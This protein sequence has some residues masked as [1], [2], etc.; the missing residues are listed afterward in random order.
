MDW[1][2]VSVAI[3]IPLIVSVIVWTLTYIIPYIFP[4][5][6]SKVLLTLFKKFQNPKDPN[7]IRVYVYQ[8]L[9]YADWK[10]LTAKGVLE[11]I[12]E[13][14][15]INFESEEKEFWNY[16]KNQVES[17]P[18]EDAIKEI[19]NR[20]NELGQPV[21]IDGEVVYQG[22]EAVGLSRTLDWYQDIYE[23]NKNANIWYFKELSRNDLH[24]ILNIDPTPNLEQGHPPA[25]FMGKEMPYRGY[26]SEELAK[27]IATKDMKL[28][29]VDGS[30]NHN[31]SDDN[32]IPSPE[33][34]L[35]EIEFEK[36]VDTTKNEK[37]K[38]FNKILLNL[39][40]NEEDNIKGLSIALSDMDDSMA[41]FETIIKEGCDITPLK[42]RFLNKLRNIEEKMNE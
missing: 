37:Y 17:M 39:N 23:K 10:M 15:F 35:K 28:I 21:K 24:K 33:T 12:F 13:K 8:Y 11:F 26:T 41:L 42:T 29:E 34:F 14:K 4:R 22:W 27:I 32:V 30:W 19:K 16:L 40:L 6:L 1:T 2:Q 31:N 3:I 9:K 25:V 36:P 38:I 20:L 5:Q 7:E 18:I